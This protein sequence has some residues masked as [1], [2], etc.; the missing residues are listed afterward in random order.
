MTPFLKISINDPLIFN[1]NYKRKDC[2]PYL[3]SNDSKKYVTEFMKWCTKI[4]RISD[5]RTIFPNITF[6][7]APVTEGRFEKLP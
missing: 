6:L 4:K 5:Q 2:H 1:S 3:L 7:L